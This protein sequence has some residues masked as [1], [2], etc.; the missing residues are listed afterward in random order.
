MMMMARIAQVVFTATQFDNVEQVVFW[1]DGEPI[2]YL[3]GEGIVLSEPQT[4]SSTERSLTGG[5]LFD[6]PAPGATL[7]SPIVVT[8]EGDVFE[9]DFPIVIERNGIEVAGPFIV[10]AGA[11]G[12]W[13]DFE[14]TILLDVAPGS[15]ELVARDESGCDTL[16]CPPPTETIIPLTLE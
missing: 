5:I 1:M 9:A 11:W 12:V 14:A 3:G 16:E 4:R 15:I 7:S 13:A 8:G 6:M 10:S 2:E